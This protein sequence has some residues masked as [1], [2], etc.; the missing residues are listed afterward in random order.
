MTDDRWPMADGRWRGQSRGWM[1][2][3]I[4]L[5]YFGTPR[6]QRVTAAVRR[7]CQNAGKPPLRKGHS[8]MSGMKNY[9]EL[10][11]WKLAMTMVETTYQVTQALPEQERYGLISQMHKCAVSIP[12]NIAEG[13]AR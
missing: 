6:D 13:Q 4:C 10:D 7:F 2:N 9:R 8:G 11:A 3:S 12:S 5:S 1:W